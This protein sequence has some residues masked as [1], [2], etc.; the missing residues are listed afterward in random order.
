[1]FKKWLIHK[2]G[3]YTASEVERM[4]DKHEEWAIEHLTGKNGEVVP[5][6][7]HYFPFEGDDILILRSDISISNAKLTGLKVAPW[8][9]HVTA[10]DFTI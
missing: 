5:D 3:G 9:K 1:M 10:S 2:L 8:T 4:R 7:S 6:C